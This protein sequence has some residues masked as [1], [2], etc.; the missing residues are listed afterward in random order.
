MQ[1]DT[2]PELPEI[3]DCDCPQE[4]LGIVLNEFVRAERK[5]I[6][7]ENENGEFRFFFNKLDDIFYANFLPALSR[8]GKYYENI[9]NFLK[10]CM[11]GVRLMKQRN[12]KGLEGAA[13]IGKHLELQQKEA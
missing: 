10:F 7:Y 2:I 13:R 4:D 12:K 8:P 11:E 9:Y 1:V 5:L 3:K 6:I